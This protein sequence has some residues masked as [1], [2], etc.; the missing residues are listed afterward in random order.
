MAERRGALISFEGGDGVGKSTQLRLLATR[1]T[2][3]GRDVIITREPGGSEGAEAIR[4]LLVSGDPGRW[5]AMTEAL[6]MF[7]ARRDHWERVI[8]PALARG[9]IVLT[10]RF[11][12]STL[13]YQGLAGA[14]GEEPVRALH[15]LAI[16]G[17]QPDL[18]FILDLPA[19]QS[20]ERLGGRPGDEARFEAKGAA[21]Q[22]SVRQ[23]FLQIARDEPNRCVIV[24]SDAAIEDVAEDIWR[25]AQA[26]LLDGDDNKDGAG[27][28][29]E[30]G[31][32]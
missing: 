19:A 8:S 27:A 11:V 32:T 30:E 17:A 3:A 26:R 14:L 20:A 15:D 9:A 28:S 6:L 25:R 22:E 10:D 16:G 18:T 24:A 29:G 2:E 12:D 21:F 7:A 13:A 5:S 23:A 31:A 1:L 4:A